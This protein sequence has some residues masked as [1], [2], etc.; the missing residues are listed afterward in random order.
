M[1]EDSIITTPETP[2][3][4]A[5]EDAAFAAAFAETRGEDALQ[6]HRAT[7]SAV[8][9]EVASDA[10]AEPETAP[11]GE[12]PGTEEAGAAAPET[13]AEQP[14]L[15]A[16]LTEDQIA[17]AL[18]RSGSLQTTVDKMAG[19]I[20]QLMQQIEALRTN[21]PTTQQAQKALDLKLEKLS[22]AFP[23]LANMLREDLAGLAGGGT[24]AAELPAAAPA[25]ITQEQFDA[26]L[27]ERLKATQAEM[28]EKLEVK[29]LT[30]LH[31][32]WNQVIR[33]NEFALWRDNVLGAEQGRELMTSE[34][35][36]FISQRL[37]DFKAWLA[38]KNAPPAAPAPKPAAR[39]TRLTNA[40]LP[41]GGTPPAQAP[42][43][44]E[45]AFISAFNKERKSA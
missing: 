21:P 27:A 39:T 24:P 5:A 34:D 9:V 20:G 12:Q 2:E 32:D 43:T 37:T 4:A 6:S 35:S 38:A 42:V 36:A 45:D 7:E 31:P 28:A 3:A 19:R 41:N 22:G 29:V 14:K 10:A 11:E 8:S 26:A 44:E 15:F 18:A 16:G 40:V 1:D 30:I 33:T 17:A 13:P 23:E 25:G